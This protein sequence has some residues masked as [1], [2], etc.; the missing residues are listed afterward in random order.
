MLPPHVDPQKMFLLLGI[1]LS[2][3]EEYEVLRTELGGEGAGMVGDVL[4]EVRDEEDDELFFQAPPRPSE[5]FSPPPADS[6]RGPREDLLRLP[7]RQEEEGGGGKEGKEGKSP[8]EDW[9]PIIKPVYETQ[10]I[11]PSYEEQRH[12][13]ET[14]RR[15]RSSPSPSRTVSLP[16]HPSHAPPPLS[17]VPAQP[18]VL[19]SHALVLSP[20]SA[21]GFTPLP[22]LK[23][24]ATDEMPQATAA[25][26]HHGSQTPRKGSRRPRPKAIC[27]PPPP[28]RPHPLPHASPSA[29]PFIPS[30][31][32]SC[33][34]PLSAI[35]W[36]SCP[37]RH[38]RILCPPPTQEPCTLSTIS[39]LGSTTPLDLQESF[40]F[41]F[42]DLLTSQSLPSPP[43]PSLPLTPLLLACHPPPEGIWAWGSHPGCGR[44]RRP[45]QRQRK[46]YGRGGRGSRL[47]GRQ[48][49]RLASSDVRGP[50]GADS[51]PRG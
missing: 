7:V 36:G 45:Y 30:S 38:L 22:F 41:P 16:S 48:L 33:C 44:R 23:P 2:R 50:Q 10:L 25:A 15:P 19:P 20:R 47:P 4:R 9:D 11:I 31:H 1:A 28:P 12:Q 29:A 32:L 43:I 46:P 24:A 35:H 39:M 5:P 3:R 27:P 37:R 17:S 51:W 6:L 26:D 40:A 8:R 21:A 13:E 34:L 49:P 18:L 42:L 14:V